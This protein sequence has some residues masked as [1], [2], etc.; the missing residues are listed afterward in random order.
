M[1]FLST[2]VLEWLKWEIIV[3]GSSWRKT[4]RLRS[5]ELRRGRQLMALGGQIMT[6]KDIS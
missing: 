3:F 4:T 6:E 1:E 5:N 2:E